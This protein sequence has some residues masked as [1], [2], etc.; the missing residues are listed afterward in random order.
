MVYHYEESACQPDINFLPDTKRHG[1]WNDTAW[2]NRCVI[3]TDKIHIFFTR[4]KSGLNPNPH[5]GNR[6]SGDIFILKVSD[7]GTVDQYGKS[8]YVDLKEGD[9]GPEGVSKFLHDF[10]L[11]TQ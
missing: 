2:N 10:V 6:V 11:R 3:G 9:L 8:F 1:H 4:S 7:A 5:V